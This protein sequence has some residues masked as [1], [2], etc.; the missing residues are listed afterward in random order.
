MHCMLLPF[1]LPIGKICIGPSVQVYKVMTLVHKSLNLYSFL[2]CNTGVRPDLEE[3][4]MGS[5]PSQDVTI[6]YIIGHLYRCS[7]LVMVI[8]CKMTTLG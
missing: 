6:T 5:A 2:F 3:N 1:V 4:K 8:R 7:Q